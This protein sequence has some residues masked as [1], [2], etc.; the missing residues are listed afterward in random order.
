MESQTLMSNSYSSSPPHSQPPHPQSYSR[1][2]EDSLNSPLEV[3]WQN[4]YEEEE[5]YGG[6]SPHD[7]SDEEWSP[8][9]SHS[10]KQHKEDVNSSDH[11]RFVS[12]I[13]FLLISL[14]NN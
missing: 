12:Y 4:D 2:R 14:N 11:C 7:W 6:D 1:S 8:N 9:P 3:V 13:Y 5:R 10:Q